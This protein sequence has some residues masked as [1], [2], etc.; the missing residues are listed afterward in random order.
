MFTKKKE[1]ILFA[2][3]IVAII[4]MTVKALTVSGRYDDLINDLDKQLQE[5]K[6]EI[7]ALKT[8]ESKTTQDDDDEF[9]YLEAEFSSD[10]EDLE[11]RLSS[12]ISYLA[13]KLSADMRDLETEL[14]NHRHKFAS[15]EV[16]FKSKR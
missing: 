15:G 5:C 14:K 9:S 7:S 1:N 3:L 16:I 12:D 13:T 10:I 6:I 2:F 8:G 4:A 11:A